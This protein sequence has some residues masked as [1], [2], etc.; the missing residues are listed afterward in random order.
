MEQQ[1][2]EEQLDHPS[3]TILITGI[4][5]RARTQVAKIAI[6][7]STTMH[8]PL[9]NRK[10]RIY[11]KQSRLQHKTTALRLSAS[12]RASFGRRDNFLRAPTNIKTGIWR[13]SKLLNNGAARAQTVSPAL[14]QIGCPFWICMIIASSSEQL[15]IC[16]AAIATRV[17][18]ISKGDMTQKHVRSQE[19]SR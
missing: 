12:E 16:R 15:H 5:A 4:R 1:Q 19:A 8:R 6:P 3:V 10:T 2:L 7:W 18:T 17:E 11:S 14:V 9:K 13:I